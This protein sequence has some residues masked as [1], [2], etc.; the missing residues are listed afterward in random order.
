MPASSSAKTH[1]TA[2]A[3]IP[4]AEIW[5]PIQAIRRRHDRHLQ[6]WMPHINLLYPF[7]PK[8]RFPEAVSQLA[9]A[10]AQVAAFQVTLSRF[11]AF[12]HR[13]GSSTL[14]LAPEPREACVR[15]QETLQT[16]FPAYD[17]LSRFAGGYTPHLSVGQAR[18]SAARKALRHDLQ[19]AW[20]PL[21]FWLAA[22][23][24]IQ[25]DQTGPFRVHAWI[26]LG[27]HRASSAPTSGGST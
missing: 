7:V 15:L 3:I 8:V 13:S 22:I 21:R 20:T 14:W 25:R 4:P 11:R 17:D 27:R 24:L 10:C 5:G 23:A 16:H 26:P 1:C 18:S 9:T 2:V 6:R 19:A 12:S